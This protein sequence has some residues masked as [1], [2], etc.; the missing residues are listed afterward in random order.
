[1]VIAERHMDRNT[2]PLSRTVA[3]ASSE[4]RLLLTQ[5]KKGKGLSP[6]VLNLAFGRIREAR[7]DAQ[8]TTDSDQRKR[9]LNKAD[10]LIKLIAWGIDPFEH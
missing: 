2:P 9:L 3:K 5:A 4:N 8:T 10:T 7:A 6:D 1:M